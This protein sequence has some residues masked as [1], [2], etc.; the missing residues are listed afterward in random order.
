MK[1]LV[2]KFFLLF[3]FAAGAEDFAKSIS[4]LQC[5]T[6]FKDWAEDLAEMKPAAK[7]FAKSL[8]REKAEAKVDLKERDIIFV[9]LTWPEMLKPVLSYWKMYQDC[10]NVHVKLVTKM[11]PKSFSEWKACVEHG[12][13][14]EPLP[15]IYEFL[16]GCYGKMFEK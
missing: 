7:E 16:R 6:D 14:R 10:A 1:S 12:Y 11:T 15:E 3:S 5:P 4:E 2:L 8:N 9:T 13:G